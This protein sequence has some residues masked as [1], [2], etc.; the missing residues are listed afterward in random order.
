[1]VF[2]SVTIDGYFT[3]KNGDMSW[4]HKQDPEWNDFVANNA[5]SGGELLFG[6]VTYDLMVSF[7]PTP[8]AAQMFPDVAKGMNDAPKVVFSRTMDKASW[9]NARLFKG[10]LENEVRKLKAEPGDQLVLMGSGQIVSQLAQAEL[11]DEYQIVLNPIVLGQGRTMFD[12]VKN[13]LNLKLTNTR[14]F[15]NGNVLLTYEPAQ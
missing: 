10:D 2:N 1:M 4:A 11:I 13:K 8:A 12:G 9:N 3:D 7:W 5:K 6:R 15:K 14:S